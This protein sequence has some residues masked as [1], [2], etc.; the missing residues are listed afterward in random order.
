MDRGHNEMK[1]IFLTGF[2]GA[3]KSTIGKALADNINYKLLD[4]DEWIETIH[5]KS[6]SRIFSDEGEA[7]FRTYETNAL[8]TL[9]NENIVVTTGGGIV[10]NEENRKIMKE[11][12]AVIY[13]HCEMEEI[14]RRT[15][16]DTT[17]P[18]LQNKSKE[19]VS[20]LFKQRLPYYEDSDYQ[21]DTTHLTVPQIV[22]K[23]LN[24]LNESKSN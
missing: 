11:K 2:M 12:G 9:P 20:E 24:I 1:I 4:T 17:R 19:Q 8:K 22:E 13:L 23:I 3:G 10:V 18:L 14:L 15:K 7:A 5:G 16:G 6:I 21:V